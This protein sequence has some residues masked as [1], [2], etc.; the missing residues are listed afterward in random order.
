MAIG[1]SPCELRGC[2]SCTHATQFFALTMIQARMFDP[3]MSL[4]LIP[5]QALS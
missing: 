4:G 5:F 1:A 3:R 2:V